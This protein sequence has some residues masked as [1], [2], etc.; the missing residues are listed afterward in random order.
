MGAALQNT[1]AHTARL[2]ELDQMRREAAKQAQAA[3]ESVYA[4]AG[5]A[6][7]LRALNEAN[8]RLEAIVQEIAQLGAMNP[9]DL[10]GAAS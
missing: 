1:L 4:T 2:A 5:T 6:A 10:T 7:G 3:E 8:A 9:T